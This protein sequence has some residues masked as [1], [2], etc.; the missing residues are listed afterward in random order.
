MCARTCV[1]R[2][3]ETPSAFVSQ[4]LLHG[5]WNDKQKPVLSMS[6]TENRGQL[7]RSQI[8]RRKPYMSGRLALSCAQ[9]CVCACASQGATWWPFL[10]PAVA[11]RLNMVCL[12]QQ[13]YSSNSHSVSASVW[14]SAGVL[15]EA[16][17]FAAGQALLGFL[18]QLEK[19]GGSLIGCSIEFCVAFEICAVWWVSC[20]LQTRPAGE[21]TRKQKFQLTPPQVFSSGPW[22]AVRHVDPHFNPTNSLSR[23]KCWSTSWGRSLASGTPR[24]SAK[25]WM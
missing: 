3:S 17:F 22:K 11:H 20:S 10:P 19:E 6:A 18:L 14:P 8:A 12:N 13:N 24:P 4:V 16:A 5:E 7:S 15:V 23:V 21:G 2:E 9:T 1:R 25:P